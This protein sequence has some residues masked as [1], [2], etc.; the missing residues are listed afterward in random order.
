MNIQIADSYFES[1]QAV[2]QC[3]HQCHDEVVCEMQIINLQDFA[4][5]TFNMTYL[6][7]LF[8]PVHLLSPPK[9]LLNRLRG[10]SSG[11]ILAS[12]E[13]SL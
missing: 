10:R 11:P 5:R 8:E 3:V 6:Y 12:V 7:S 13:V 4:R 9:H 2:V 1:P